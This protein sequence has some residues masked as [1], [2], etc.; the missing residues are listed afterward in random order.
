MN[1]LGMRI[2]EL[3]GSPHTPPDRT[4]ARDQLRMSCIQLACN[5]AQQRMAHVNWDGNYETVRLDLFGTAQ[6]MFEFVTRE[7]DRGAN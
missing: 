3:G 6:R 4:V 2:P 1:N 7:T 5:L